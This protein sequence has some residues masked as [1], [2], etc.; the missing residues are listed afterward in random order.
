MKR[1][2]SRR[3]ADGWRIWARTPGRSNSTCR[4]FQS[5]PAGSSTE[6]VLWAWW[7]DEGRRIVFLES[8]RM[9]LMTVDVTEGDAI[10]AGTPRLVAT[11]P[12]GIVWIDAMPDRQRFLALVPERTGTG[13]VTVVQNW[14]AALKK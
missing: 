12:K 1:L 5:R 3:T 4:R 11:V 10:K 2:R 9:R 13:T 8:N 14:I 6:G 7:S